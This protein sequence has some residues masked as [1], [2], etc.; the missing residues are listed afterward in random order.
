MLAIPGIG[1]IVAVGAVTAAAAYAFTQTQMF[2]DLQAKSKEIED[3]LAP[4]QDLLD[5]G[6]MMPATAASPVTSDNQNNA[7]RST[8]IATMERSDPSSN[9][10]QLAAAALAKLDTRMVDPG[11]A[12]AMAVPPSTANAVRESTM[13]SAAPRQP[14]FVDNSTRGGDMNVANNQ[15]VI[16]ASLFSHDRKDP[17]MHHPFDVRRGLV[18]G[19]S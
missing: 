6:G 12:R 7:L 15:S 3:S 8:Y 5:E 2:R 19:L 16:G 14:M 10:Y 13:T 1:P 17:A 18:P 9:E 4:G 11:L